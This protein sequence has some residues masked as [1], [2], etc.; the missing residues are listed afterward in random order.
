MIRLAKN[1]EIDQIL[2]ITRACAQKMIANGIYQWNTDYPSREAF[3]NDVARKEL[4]VLER[5]GHLL[6]SIVVSTFKD[7]IYDTITWLTTDK[8]PSLYIH[9]LAVHPKFQGQGNAQKLMDFAENQAK[10]GDFQSVRLDT[11][12]QNSRNQHFYEQRGYQKL[13][14]VYFH[15]QSKYPFYCYELPLN[16]SRGFIS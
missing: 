6:G 9:R 12:S 14:S 8:K 2:A 3:E 7:R 1:E 10:I 16:P 15:K 5:E 13:G 11:F 4:Y